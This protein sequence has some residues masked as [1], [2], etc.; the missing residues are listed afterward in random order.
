M[1]SIFTIRHFHRQ[2]QGGPHPQ[3]QGCHH[4]HHRNPQSQ[5]GH[6]CHHRY[7]LEMIEIFFEILENR[8]LLLSV[9]FAKKIF[10]CK[11]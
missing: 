2:S 5:V 6:R 3:Y 8:F 1:N 9:F 11:N 7:H 4:H 10:C